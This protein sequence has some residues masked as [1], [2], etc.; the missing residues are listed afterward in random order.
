MYDNSKEFLKNN[1]EIKNFAVDIAKKKIL[2]KINENV[3]EEYK[4]YANLIAE[5]S[6]N[7]MKQSNEI[8]EKEKNEEKKE[9][10]E[11]NQEKI[12]SEKLD[13]ELNNVQPIDENVENLNEEIDNED[14]NN[15]SENNESETIDM[16]P[17]KAY[18]KGMEFHKT[19]EFGEAF[20]MFIFSA[21]KGNA[22]AQ[23]MV[24]LYYHYGKNGEKNKELAKKYYNLSADQ[25]NEQAIGKLKEL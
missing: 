15:N 9:E 18:E 10:E 8:E 23:Y 13:Q 5:E 25:K 17:A 16:D 22:K 24:G 21:D 20:K 14:N 19:N 12:E 7:Q 4:Q 1:P 6:F 11:N 3:P 2:E